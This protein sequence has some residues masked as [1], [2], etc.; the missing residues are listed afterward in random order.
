MHKV[1][2]K[3]GDTEALGKHLSSLSRAADV[4]AV[5]LAL[6]L[7]SCV[8]LSQSTYLLVPRHQP[9]LT[10]LSGCEKQMW[11]KKVPERLV[12]NLSAL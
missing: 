8:T 11:G 7:L 5:A 9:S 4:M 3:V 1:Q 12:K 10:G 6:P 2:D